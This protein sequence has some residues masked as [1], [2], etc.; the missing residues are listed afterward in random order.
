MR[1]EILHI[2]KLPLLFLSKKIF[3]KRS[4]PDYVLF[5]LIIII[6][7][8]IAHLL[9]KIDMNEDRE[10]LQ[11]QYKDISQELN[12]KTEA[13][14]KYRHKVKSLE[15]EISD[16]QSEFEVERQDYLES[17]RKQDRNIK[18]LSQISEKVAGTLKK[19]CNYR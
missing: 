10:I 15:K 14:R 4:I 11:N 2:F 3:F 12:L 13:L 7:S 9:A 18:L 5:F 8:V 17:I 6:S 19:E 1:F 16:I